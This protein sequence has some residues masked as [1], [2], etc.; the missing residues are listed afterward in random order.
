MHLSDLN[1][2]QQHNAAPINKHVSEIPVTG[3]M[4][5]KVYA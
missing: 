4:T 3:M 2:W 5:Q 1:N